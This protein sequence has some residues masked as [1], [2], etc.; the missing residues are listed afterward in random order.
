[1]V[2]CFSGTCLHQLPAFIAL[3]QRTLTMTPGGGFYFYHPVKSRKTHTSNN[4]KWCSWQVAEAGFEPLLVPFAVNIDLNS[5]SEVSSKPSPITLWISVLRWCPRDEPM[6]PFT[7]VLTHSFIIQVLSYRSF[8]C[9]VVRKYEA[10]LPSG[11]PFL[12]LSFLR[13]VIDLRWGS[14]ETSRVRGCLVM[15]FSKLKHSISEGR[16]L[17]LKFWREAH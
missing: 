11:H 4:W 3:T 9:W 12:E 7:H 1:M 14:L 17:R 15:I 5:H 16:S 13:E 2:D 8:L 10:G 6:P